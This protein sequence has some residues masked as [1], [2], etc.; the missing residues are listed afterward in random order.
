MD[1]QTLPSLAEDYPAYR[2]LKAQLA[3]GGVIQMEGVPVPAKGW[4]LAQLAARD[5]AAAGGRHL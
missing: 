4:L 1:L 2:E 5:G 3:Q